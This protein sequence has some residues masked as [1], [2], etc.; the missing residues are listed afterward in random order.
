MAKTGGITGFNL[1]CILIAA[2]LAGCTAAHQQQ[3]VLLEDD[4]S[5]LDPG[6][7]SAPVGPHTEYHYLPEAAPRGNWAVSCFTWEH[8]AQRA[9]RVLEENG[10][11][12]LAQTFE[13]KQM[14][15]THPMVIAGDT[16]WADYTLQVRFSPESGSGRSGV[17][18]RYRNDRCYYFFGLEG[19]EAVLRLV[20]HATGFHQPYEKILGRR[21]LD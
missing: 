1:V 4:F 18:F 12:V 20:R 3:A 19:G 7:F 11:Q 2:L 10:D 5:G 16:L 14:K 9:W 21:Q 6:M 13:N 17:V 8:G 15:H